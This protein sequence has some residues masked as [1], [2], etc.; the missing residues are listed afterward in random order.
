MVSVGYFVFRSIFR[1]HRL[2]GYL[3]VAKTYK[4][5][6]GLARLMALRVQTRKFLGIIFQFGLAQ[7]WFHGQRLVMLGQGPIG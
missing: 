3:I 6:I 7:R 2:A 1:P 5:P 4:L